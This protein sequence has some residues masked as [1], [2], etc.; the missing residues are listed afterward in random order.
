[1]ELVSIHISAG[2]LDRSDGLNDS[3]VSRVKLHDDLGFTESRP[4]V[5]LTL[6][7]NDSSDKPKNG[8]HETGLG[9]S[10]AWREA[11]MKTQIHRSRSW[12]GAKREA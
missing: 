10:L 9:I 11:C 6:Q 2:H 1:M 4:G 8:T 5:A 3:N 12:I 7:T